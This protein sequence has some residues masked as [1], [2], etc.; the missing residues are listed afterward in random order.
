[1]FV[2]RELGLSAGGAIGLTV[3]GIFIGGLIGV[4][5]IVLRTAWIRFT[6]GL[7]E[8]QTITLDPRKK[9][10]ALGV[11]DDCQVVIPG[12]PD[13]LRHHAAILRQGGAF[14]VEPR[15]GPVLLRGQKAYAPVDS[16]ILRHKDRLQLG[17]TRFTFLS[18]RKEDAS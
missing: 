18:E 11:A 5:E 9:E 6:R 13:V 15:D 2:S 7:L 8:G 16:H 12:D 14:V 17:K 10:Q 4:V 3:L 1:M